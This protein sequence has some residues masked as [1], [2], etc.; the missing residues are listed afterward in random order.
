[1]T[2]KL[3]WEGEAELIRMGCL[4]TSCKDCEYGSEETANNI[5]CYWLCEK[6]F[7]NGLNL[8]PLCWTEDLFEERNKL[9][10]KPKIEHIMEEVVHT[11]APKDKI[12]PNHYKSHPS[13]IETIVVTEHF[14]FSVGNSI[15]YLM[16]AGLKEGESKLTDLRK[17]KWY[18]ER[19]IARVIKYEEPNR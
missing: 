9:L 4:T 2:K 10:T 14:N 1:M 17:A 18:V 15:K 19:E 16:R 5:Y 11:N 12:N 13:G 6:R 3:K 8:T 7:T